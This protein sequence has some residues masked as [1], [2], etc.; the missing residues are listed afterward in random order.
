MA[1]PKGSHKTKASNAQF[2][3]SE[4]PSISSQPTIEAFFTRS[5]TRQKNLGDP[6][7]LRRDQSPRRQSLLKRKRALEV[8]DLT[9]DSQDDVREELPDPGQSGMES[10]DVQEGLNVMNEGPR[11]PLADIPSVEE[12]PSTLLFKLGNN[13]CR[14]A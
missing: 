5:A 6:H 12:I 13:R 3:R 4:A 1:P 11:I 7:R 10:D 9:L 14:T 2:R 8:V